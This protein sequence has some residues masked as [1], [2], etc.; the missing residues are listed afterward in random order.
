MYVII[1]GL[2]GVGESL[3]RTLINRGHTVAIIDKNED[4]CN[5]FASEVDALVICGDAGDK[6]NLDNAGADK[7][8]ALVVATGDDSVNLM[9][10]SLGK[11][12]KIPHLISVVRDPEHIQLFSKIGTTITPDEIVAEHLYQSLFRIR[13]FLLLGDKEAE[14]FTLKVEK[15]SKVVNKPASELHLPNGYTILGIFRK[16][17][18]SPLS[19][20][21]SIQPDD[22]VLIHANKLDGIKKIVEMFTG[23]LETH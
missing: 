3:A 6:E 21:L 1:V 13:D 2:S 15:N 11:E 20:D 9:V 16:G 23:K 5:T 7:A 17:K 18:L 8:D 22:E 10:G 19:K 4:R 12:F 14:I